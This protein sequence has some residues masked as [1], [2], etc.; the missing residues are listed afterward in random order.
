MWLQPTLLRQA[1]YSAA[2]AA[3]AAAAA[4][5]AGAPP[6]SALTCK[7]AR[8]RSVGVVRERWR[9]SRGSCVR[10]ACTSARERRA[11]EAGYA[12]GVE[13]WYDGNHAG[14]GGAAA[15]AAATAAACALTFRWSRDFVR[16]A[17]FLCRMPRLTFLSMIA[18][19]LERVGTATE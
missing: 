14:S 16:A 7:R 4:G 2:G 10:S 3:G 17:V 5:A 18:K 1:A 6:S 15:M 8:R 12:I 11:E 13:S 9:R 19:A